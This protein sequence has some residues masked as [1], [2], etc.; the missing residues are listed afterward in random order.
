MF[1]TYL[2]LSVS[3]YVNLYTMSNQAN[4]SIITLNALSAVGVLV[5]VLM[6]VMCFNLIFTNRHNIDSTSFTVRYKTIIADVSTHHPYCYQFA[7][8]YLV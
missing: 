3:S 2:A 1:Q 8:M 6:P 4:T 5:N 7:S